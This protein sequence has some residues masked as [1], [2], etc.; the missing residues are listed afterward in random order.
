MEMLNFIE[1]HLVVDLKSSIRMKKNLPFKN[2]F[3]VGENIRK[4]CLM[5]QFFMCTWSTINLKLVF[6]LLLLGRI[7]G[8]EKGVKQIFKIDR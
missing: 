7:V 6:S 5:K 1:S 3:P 2:F 4:K 8:K